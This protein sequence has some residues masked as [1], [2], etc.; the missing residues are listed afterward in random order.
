MRY[1]LIYFL[2]YKKN[3]LVNIK[4]VYITKEDAI[5][6]LERIA[7]EYVKELQGKQQADICKQDTTPEQLLADKAMKEGLYIRKTDD[8]IVLYS[9]TTII[10]P[11][12]IWGNSNK[13]QVQKVGQ[14]NITEYN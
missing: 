9:K 8:Y 7:I 11:G 10:I 2:D 4:D 6:N 5:N 12:T 13:L 14:F 3:D 1:Y